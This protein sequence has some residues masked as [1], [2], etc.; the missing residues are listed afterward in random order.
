MFLGCLLSFIVAF[1]STSFGFA[2]GRFFGKTRRD[3][4]FVFLINYLM[5][6]L[7]MFLVM[8]MSG[9]ACLAVVLGMS[10]GQVAFSGWLGNKDKSNV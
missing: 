7:I 1:L 4:T 8:S 5:K 3:R 2:K 10:L 9:W 6:L